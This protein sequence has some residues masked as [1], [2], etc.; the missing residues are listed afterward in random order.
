M[1]KKLGIIVPYRDRYEQ[2]ITF[3]SHIG[4]FLKNIKY[5][6]I[7]VEQD[8]AKIFNRGK[9][10]NIGFI[11]AKK[12]KCDYVIFHDVDMLPM[13]VDYSYSNKPLHL[14]TNFLPEGKRTIFDE[15][16]GGV[17]LFPIE[18]FERING[19]SNEYWGWGF[20]D[21]D[22][23]HRCK[24]NNIDLERKEIKQV[25]SNGAT[26]KFNGL[27]AF[28]KTPKIKTQR[29]YTIFISFN[30]D[31]LILNHEE[32]DDKYTIFSNDDMKLTYTSY[33]RYNFELLQEGET[34]EYINTNIKTNY[35]TNI[36]VTIDTKLNK[37][38]LYQDG[39]LIETKNYKNDFS[40][41]SE[42]HFYLGSNKDNDFFNGTIDSFVIYNS[43]LEEKEIQEISIN[44]NFGLTQSFGEY[45]KE[46]TLI[47]YY[48][49]KFI[50]HYELIDIVNYKNHGIINNCEIVGEKI[51]EFKTI[52]IPYRRD[53]TF[54][55]LE[56]DENGYVGG[57][58]KNITTRYNQ[59]KF[60]NEVSKGYKDHKK[61][62]L[63]NCEYK[64]HDK[65]KI[66]NLTH[67]VVGI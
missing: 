19:Y 52:E 49:A 57:G 21:T 10:L 25:V 53:S 30:V 63:N 43:I 8:D 56:H 23:L 5:E 9:L 7:V 26:L 45:N 50:K 42:S 47:L 59:L 33:L 18:N 34:V 37:I 28:V 12:L 11:E 46:D 1:D 39:D 35:K 65:N 58:W 16:F 38:T 32:Y 66:N 44:K 41:K 51:D 36:C 67:I 29:F 64:I 27:N 22:L 54:K 15:Y 55:L 3:K 13:E 31:D 60:Q 40:F 62:G 6:L 4:E 24:I 20:E 14:A 61:D 48:D 17:T 2:L